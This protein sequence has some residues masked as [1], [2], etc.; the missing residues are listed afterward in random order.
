MA[1]CNAN[2]LTICSLLDLQPSRSDRIR[3]EDCH[4]GSP[5]TFVR[6]TQLLLV[7][8]SSE[9]QLWDTEERKRLQALSSVTLGKSN[10]HQILLR[11]PTEHSLLSRSPRFG[12]SIGERLS[13]SRSV[14]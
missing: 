10:L 2:D 11:L 4:S 9:V 1:I 12:A 13:K 14:F 6:S 5:S 7:K 8:L 3:I